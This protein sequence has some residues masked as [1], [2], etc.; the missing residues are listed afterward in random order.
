[1]KPY[2]YKVRLR[3]CL[4][5]GSGHGDDD[6]CASVGLPNINNVSSSIA[7]LANHRCRATSTVH[8]PHPCFSMPPPTFSFPPLYP[9]RAGPHHGDR[10]RSSLHGAILR[11][12]H[13]RGTGGLPLLHGVPRELQVSLRYD[14][15]STYCS[16]L[17]PASC[18]CCH[19]KLIVVHIPPPPSLP[20]ERSLSRRKQVLSRT[21]ASWRKSL[22][23][24]DGQL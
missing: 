17:G 10:R 6:D 7:L 18:R 1:M 11:P 12:G 23:P 24:L 15:C 2:A 14:P 9:I 20:Q 4:A 21:A 13:E 19:P 16:S 8:F 22:R 5:C 3:A